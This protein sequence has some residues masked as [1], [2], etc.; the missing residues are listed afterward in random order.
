MKDEVSECCPYCG[1]GK[2][3]K[4]ENRG[5]IEIQPFE[6]EEQEESIPVDIWIC[7]ECQRRFVM[8]DPEDDEEV[9]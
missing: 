2:V 7:P 6:I 3:V 8:L 5:L 4:T 1:C 9:E